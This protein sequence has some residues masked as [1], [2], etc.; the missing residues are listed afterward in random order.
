ML[1]QVAS[2]L[3]IVGIAKG[4]AWPLLPWLLVQWFC[5]LVMLFLILSEVVLNDMYSQYLSVTS[6]SV[7]FALL[8]WVSACITFCQLRNI[9]RAQDTINNLNYIHLTSFE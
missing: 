8:N 7:L 3:L 4:R 1:F 5:I 9:K 6:G 2:V